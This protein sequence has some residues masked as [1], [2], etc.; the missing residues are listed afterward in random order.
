MKK[1]LFLLIIGALVFLPYKISAQEALPAGGDNFETAVSLSPGEYQ[2][3]AFGEE[4]D[5]YY[6]ISNIQPGQE[7]GRAHV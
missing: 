7:I 2:G 6:S 3:R 5:S 1:K 4:E